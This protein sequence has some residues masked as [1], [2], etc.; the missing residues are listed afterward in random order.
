MLA[1]DAGPFMLECYKYGIGGPGYMW[2]GSDGVT[3]PTLWASYPADEKLNIMKGFIGLRPS[4]G[5]GTTA[6][7]SFFARLRAMPSTLPDA[8]GDCNLG[9]D[10]DDDWPALLW[11]WDHDVNASTP[12][13]CA[14]SDNQLEASYAP[15][16]YDA[17][18]AYAH[19]LQ[20]LFENEGVETPTGADIL[21]AL[22][23]HVSF[24]GITGTVNLHDTSSTPGTRMFHGDR[25]LGVAYE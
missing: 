11:A 22:T 16:A 20:H 8:N 15:F 24:T 4:N 21:R 10:T 14:G 6:Y 9:T 3:T 5:R 2:V 1:S 17:V 18:Y 7:N 23:S 25:R 13:R 19:A 12:M